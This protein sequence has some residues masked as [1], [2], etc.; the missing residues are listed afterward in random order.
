[1]IIRM[2][3]LLGLTAVTVLCCIPL[4]AHEPVVRARTPLAIPDLPGYLTLKCDF[5]IH[6]VFSDGSVWPTVRAEEAW[7]EGLDAI[8][9]TDHI[10][11]QPHKDDVPVNHNRAYDLAR[12]HGEAL[13]VIVIRGSEITRKM[14]PGHLNAI[15]LTN[16]AALDV[17]DWRQ[18]LAEAKRQ[19]AFIFWNH[20]GW[21]AQLEPDG[22]VRWYPEHT[23]LLEAGLLHGIEV[24]NGRSVYHSSDTA[25]TALL[26]EAAPRAVE[27]LL[28]PINGKWGNLNVEQAVALTAAVGPRFVLPNHYD[29]MALNAENPETFRWFCQQR[30]LT[31]RCVI[32]TVMQPF[33]WE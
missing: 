28:V 13:D 1:M 20:P 17:E 5:H 11:Y 16:S 9:I 8:A 19:G 31:S 26:L 10:E 22:I 27:V 18:A 2:P 7:R 15:F 32:P 23:E 3:S 30:Q 29:L 24:A 25:F 14:P 33:L 21:S 12:P 4:L 6:T